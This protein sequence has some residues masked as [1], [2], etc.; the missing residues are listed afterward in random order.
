MTITNELIRPFHDVVGQFIGTWTGCG[1]V[2]P[3][4]WGY[5]GATNGQWRF[6]LAL[7]DKHVLADY[8]EERHDGSAFEGHGLMMQD[9]ESPDVLWFWFDSYGYPPIPEAR[10][11]HG[12]TALIFEKVTPR[13]RGRTTLSIA[14]E[15]LHHEAAFQP[16]DASSFVI[17][18]R[19]SY[20][21][22]TASPIGR[23]YASVCA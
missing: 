13:G 8:R 3:N 6:S 11:R 15:H 22:N 10:G 14:G 21:R 2:L 5:S 23:G 4:P 16:H 7:G 12:G 18:A 1:E 17:V 9:Q 19:G 20:E